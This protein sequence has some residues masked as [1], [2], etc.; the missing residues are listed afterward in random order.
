MI[1]SRLASK[2]T[3]ALSFEFAAFTGGARTAHTLEP[4]TRA[5]PRA[6]RLKRP[7][8]YQA[9]PRGSRRD[10]VRIRPVPRSVARPARVVEP[11]RRARPLRRGEPS[12][13]D[14]AAAVGGLGCDPPIG[15]HWNRAHAPHRAQG[16]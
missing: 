1:T 13:P 16:G 12:L 7:G 9:P 4:R 6:R 15:T 5:P 14:L 3:A 8:I 10:E 2:L 11:R